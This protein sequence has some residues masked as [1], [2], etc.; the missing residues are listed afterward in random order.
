MW[1]WGL[2]GYLAAMNFLAAVLTVWDKHCARRGIR[3]VPE[4]RLWGVAI[5]G[6]AAGMLCVM[7]HIRHKTRHR[8]FMWGLPMLIAAHAATVFTFF[9]FYY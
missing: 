9:T 8:A 5:L 6:G 3:R 7:R 2:C 4:A 1:V